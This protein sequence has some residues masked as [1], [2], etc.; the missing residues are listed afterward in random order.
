MSTTATDI[1]ATVTRPTGDELYGGDWNWAAEATNAWAWAA[2][3][4]GL[5]VTVISLDVI[6]PNQDAAIV[7]VDGVECVLTLTGDE[8]RAVPTS[9]DDDEE[10]EDECSDCGASLSEPTVHCVDCGDHIDA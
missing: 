6:D 7:Q 9:T 8:V 5:T 4:A 2:R 10:E 1:T 3:R